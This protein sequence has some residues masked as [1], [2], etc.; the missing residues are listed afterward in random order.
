MCVTVVATMA[1]DDFAKAFFGGF[2]YSDPFR[3]GTMASL[4][5]MPLV[6]LGADWL[7]SGLAALAGK[8]EAENPRR[9]YRWLAAVFS[10]L[11]LIVTFGPNFASSA[12][13]YDRNTPSASLTL[14]L[15]Y[16]YDDAPYTAEESSFVK[17]AMNLVGEDALVLNQP[18]DGSFYAYG[19]DGLKTYYRKFNGYGVDKETHESNY[20]RDHLSAAATDAH[21]RDIL[22]EQDIH[23][24]LILARENI[25]SSFVAGQYW[26][27]AWQGIDTLTDD[28][29]GFEIV[30]QQG[31]MRLYRIS[32]I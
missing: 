8:I 10:A 15:W 23:Y 21:V 12:N 5:A 1:G 6:V 31:D 4:A 24:V 13:H 16:S 20:L 32:C 14:G 30:L 29:P 22:R 19:Q 28:T 26:P 2:W 3:C 27:G 9:A 25:A 18:N 17:E 11:F 7:A